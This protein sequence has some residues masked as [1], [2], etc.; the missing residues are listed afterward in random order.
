MTARFELR[1]AESERCDLQR[2]ADHTGLSASTIVRFG[3]RWAVGRFDVLANGGAEKTKR[4]IAG[5]LE[6]LRADPR[7]ASV[8]VELDGAL[9][10]LEREGDGVPAA[11]AL[12]DM[13]GLI[14]AEPIPL[15]ERIRL[16]GELLE[17]DGVLSV[18]QLPDTAT[19]VQR[20]GAQPQN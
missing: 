4:D 18:R 1:L 6:E 16:L 11:A 5:F 13:V 7:L 10:A 2:S 17:F 14:A 15:A 12:H 20:A 8:A 9:A 19:F 3:M